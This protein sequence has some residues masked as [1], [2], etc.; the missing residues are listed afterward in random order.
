M[1][2]FG[3]PGST[4]PE[5]LAEQY[6]TSRLV[7]IPDLLAPGQVDALLASMQDTPTSRVTCNNGAVNWQEK[8]FGPG[9]PAYDFFERPDSMNLVY[10]LTGLRDYEGLMCWASIYGPGEYINPHRDIAGTMH[11]LVC[12]KAPDSSMNGGALVIGDK[13]LS[14]A[15]GAAVAF[16]ATQQEHYTE[17]LIATHDNPEPER[18]VLVG[19]YFLR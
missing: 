14:L 2:E 12:L 3:K 4:Y 16:D 13:R 5:S 7:H 15:P 10:A 18:I 1:T 17:P 8:N 6:E 9:H 11:L 19:R